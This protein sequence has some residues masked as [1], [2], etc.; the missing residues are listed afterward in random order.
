M[1]LEILTRPNEQA[2]D[3]ELNRLGKQFRNIDSA[4]IS[5]IEAFRKD[6]LRDEQRLSI[7]IDGPTLA[8]VLANE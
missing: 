7:V 2:L 8:F 3:Q 6:N 1:R 4:N 5:D